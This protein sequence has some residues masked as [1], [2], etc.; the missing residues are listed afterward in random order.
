MDIRRQASLDWAPGFSVGHEVLDTQHRE[1]LRI[2]RLAEMSIDDDSE[3]GVDLFHVVLNDLCRYAEVHFATEEAI[4][5]AI[6]YPQLDEQRT[7]HR[8]YL[9]ELADFLFEATQGKADPVAL[10]RFLTGWWL[11]HILD[12]DMRYAPFV[13]GADPSTN[14]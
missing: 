13:R 11:H 12:S 3:T 4:L 6:G 10:A 9:D 2:C 7:E 14:G 5:E 1:L 8:T